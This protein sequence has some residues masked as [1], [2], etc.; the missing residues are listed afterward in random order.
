M[1]SWVYK[2]REIVGHENVWS[3]AR[4]DTSVDAK[5][6]VRACSTRRY[7]HVF[8]TS[9][10][11]VQ[12]QSTA[13]ANSL[14]IGRTYLELSRGNQTNH[15]LNLLAFDSQWCLLSTHV[16]SLLSTSHCDL[17]IVH[18]RGKQF[19]ETWWL[20]GTRRWVKYHAISSVTV[21]TGIRPLSY[22]RSRSQSFLSRGH[23]PVCRWRHLSW[24]LAPCTTK[25]LIR[26]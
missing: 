11:S 7:V 9:S 19:D 1:A 10:C 8:V 22:F 25:I 3:D 4:R 12:I 15:L 17:S 23:T 16:T 14:V 13:S 18:M 21:L 20:N 26:T 6:H 2:L 24:S 5:A